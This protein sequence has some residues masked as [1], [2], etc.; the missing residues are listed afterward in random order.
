MKSNKSRN[1]AKGKLSD[2]LAAA[3]VKA[4]AELSTEE[5]NNLGAKQFVYPKDRRFPIPDMAHAKN[6]LARSS[7]KPEESK[8]KAAV[9][10]KFPSLAAHDDHMKAGEAQDDCPHCVE[11]AMM[12]KPQPADEKKRAIEMLQSEH[13]EK[14]GKHEDCPY[15]AARSDGTACAL[16][17]GDDSLTLTGPIATAPVSGI[18]GSKEE[19]LPEH[20]KG[21]KGSVKSL[22]EPSEGACET[23]GGEPVHAVETAGEGITASSPELGGEEQEDE[24]VGEIGEPWSLNS[25]SS[26]DDED[27][28]DPD[29]DDEDPDDDDE[30]IRTKTT[31]RT[32]DERSDAISSKLRA[33]VSAHHKPQAGCVFCPAR[34]SLHGDDTISP[35]GPVPVR[36]VAPGGESEMG[37]AGDLGTPIN[38]P[39]PPSGGDA[40]LTVGRNPPAEGSTEDPWLPQGDAKSHP[41]TG[42]TVRVIH[43]GGIGGTIG[44]DGGRVTH[45]SLGKVL[46]VDQDGSTALVDWASHGK[47]RISLINIE[48][49]KMK[50]EETEGTEESL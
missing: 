24:P 48:E 45:G 3:V 25:K 34:R 4:D 29:D 16:H 14:H 13:D 50:P 8:V 6:A 49:A 19:A 20:E 39:A 10:K 42:K 32:E 5:R 26:F 41:M 15:C 22:G 17:K 46:E 33:H 28:E 12:G 40:V 47:G 36:S 38:P 30:E 31:R 27:D 11:D 23:E 1:K 35:H 44:E 9:H 21:A 37:V 18:N 43:H 2:K 7:G